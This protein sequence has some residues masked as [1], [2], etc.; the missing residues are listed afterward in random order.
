MFFSSVLIKNAKLVDA[1]DTCLADLLIESGKISKIE[2]NISI[3]AEKEIDA[4]GMYVFPGFIDPHVHLHLPTPAG[5]SADNFSS[6]SMAAIY[7]G[8]TSAMDFVTPIKGQ[9]LIDAFNKRFSEAQDSV[10]NLKFHVSPV[11]WNVFTACEMNELVEKFNVNSFKIYTAYKKSVGIGNDVILKVFEQ[12]AKLNATVLVHAEN[13]EIIDFL[14]KKFIEQGKTQPLYHCLSRPREAEIEAVERVL[15]FAKLTGVRLYFV[16]ISTSEAIKL[17]E[18]AK[19]QGMKVYAETCPHYLLLDDSCY[20]GDFFET[21]KYVLS[22]P[23]RKT[24]DNEALW[25][26]IENGTI[27][28][29]ATDHCPFNTFGQKEKGIND[30]TKIPNGAGGIENRISLMYT[31]GVLQNKMTLNK[32]VELCCTNAAKIF[33]FTS[34]GNLKIG[35][36]ADIV[37]FDP[38]RVSTISAQNQVSLCDSNIY[39]GFVV[40]GVFNYVLI[41]RP[42][43]IQLFELS[44]IH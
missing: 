26:A 25:Q 31:Y 42:N 30:F 33:G 13:D 6:A 40:N 1:Q 5:Y 18:N 19:K 34:K 36:D 27:D 10:I 35:F 4:N 3:N 9:S 43:K 38:N 20:K 39:E 29:I 44:K 28:T 17:I 21:A 37:I 16:H 15:N 11:D 41:S 2:S 8:T 23:L 14:Q 24:T 7:G 32:M 12:A 22:P